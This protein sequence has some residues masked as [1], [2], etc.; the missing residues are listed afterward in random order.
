MQTM[1]GLT[2]AEGDMEAVIRLRSDRARVTASHVSVSTHHL[3]GVACFA[4]A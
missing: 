3:G 1:Q 4:H 2:Q